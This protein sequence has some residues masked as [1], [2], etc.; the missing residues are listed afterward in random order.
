MDRRGTTVST[1]R[2]EKREDKHD[3][4]RDAPCRKSY[5]E[6]GRAL[7]RRE[8]Q[9]TV[10]ALSN[11]LP[12]LRGHAFRSCSFRDEA[13]CAQW[14]NLSFTVAGRNSQ[15]SRSLLRRKSGEET[16][17]HHP[18]LPRIKASQ[19]IQSVIE[20]VQ[21]HTSGLEQVNGVVQGNPPPA[22]ALG[23]V[24]AASVFDQDLSH[25]LCRDGEEMGAVLKFLG[26]LL[27]QAE[28]GLMH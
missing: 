19:L 26:L 13:R 10:Q 4:E 25:E 22:I 7:L 27:L 14:P 2:H 3:T 21:I 15:N 11:L 24:P 1:G 28:I 5:G 16:Q 12:A 17:L 6:E 8:F 20:S 18:T 23:S 9:R